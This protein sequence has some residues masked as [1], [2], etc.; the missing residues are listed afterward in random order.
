MST[1]TISG[2]EAISPHIETGTPRL[3]PRRDDLGR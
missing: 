2:S 3:A 1:G